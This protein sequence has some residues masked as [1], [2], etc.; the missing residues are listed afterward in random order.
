MNK[1]LHAKRWYDLFQ[2]EFAK[3]TDRAAVILSA[4]MLDRVLENLLRTRLVPIPGSE[5]SLFN[6]PYAPISTFSA[7][8]D[9][10][11]R[12]GLISANL[13]R[14]LHLIRRIR[15]DFAHDV[16]NCS[17]E[18][19]GTRDRILE[20]TQSSG[21]ADRHPKMRKIFPLGTRGDFQMTVAWILW[22]LTCEAEEIKPLQTC[23]VEW[24]YDRRV[25][26]THEE[27]E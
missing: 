23:P 16:T 6:A 14:D 12:I 22:R 21:F 3:E 10:A 18:H 25:S 17:F 24:G 13:C 11:Y 8:I 1:Y 15:N 5:D 7:K 4:A 20:L 27:T 19:A 26:E 9:L 2:K